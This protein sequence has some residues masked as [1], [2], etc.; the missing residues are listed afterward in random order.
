MQKKTISLLLAATMIFSSA[1]SALAAAVDVTKKATVHNK[2]PQ[3]S[4]IVKKI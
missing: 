2:A 1:E 4:A 3:A